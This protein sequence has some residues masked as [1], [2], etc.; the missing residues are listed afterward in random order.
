MRC[1][2]I[3]KDT[4]N[5]VWFGMKAK[6]VP[7]NSNDKHDNYAN[8]LEGVID[9]LIQR[10][11][12]IKN[13]LWYDYDTGIPLIDKVKSKATIDAYVAETVLSH[14]DVLAIEG[15]ASEMVK[16]KYSCFFIART[17]YGKAE[18]SL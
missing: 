3:D 17:V 18:V 16:S 6:N 15:F 14:P 12:V 7:Q 1:R 10:L 11:S 8:E 5:I 9:S 13:E 4:G 2:R